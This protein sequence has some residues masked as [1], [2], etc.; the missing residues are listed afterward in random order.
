MSQ[1]VDNLLNG[2]WRN[3]IMMLAGGPA[4]PDCPGFTQETASVPRGAA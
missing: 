1:K 3:T 4:N 2:N